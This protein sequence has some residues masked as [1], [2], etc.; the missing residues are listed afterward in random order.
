MYF[1]PVRLLETRLVLI[2]LDNTASLR[3]FSLACSFPELYIAQK[4]FPEV[5]N[6]LTIIGQEMVEQNIV[7]CR[8][9]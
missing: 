2:Q 6:Q 3:T 8:Q 9:W 5:A 1:C 4:D 7:I